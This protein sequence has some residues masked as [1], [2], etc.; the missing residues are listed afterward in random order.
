MNESLILIICG[1]IG[2]LIPLTVLAG[3]V[4]ARRH[5]AQEWKKITKH[6]EHQRWDYPPYTPPRYV[7]KDDQA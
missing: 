4:L 6:Y 2:L 7:D 3:I 1:S 5:R